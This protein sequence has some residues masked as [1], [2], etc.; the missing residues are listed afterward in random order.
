LSEAKIIAAEQEREYSQSGIAE[1]TL[2]PEKKRYF[3]FPLKERDIKIMGELAEIDNDT[4]QQ[5]IKV[6]Q[7]YLRITNQNWYQSNDAS[8][9]ASDCVSNRYKD[10]AKRLKTDEK[11]KGLC[12]KF[13]QNCPGKWYRAMVRM[14]MKDCHWHSGETGSEYEG[15]TNPK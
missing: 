7:A 1:G 15:H 4:W 12:Q 10:L 3:E 5:I 9:Y 14:A 11:I 13:V 8:F 2:L 6:G